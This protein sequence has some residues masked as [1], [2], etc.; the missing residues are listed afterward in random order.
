MLQEVLIGLLQSGAAGALAY[1]LV[2]WL[3]TQWE[4]FANAEPWVRRTTAW[5]LSALLGALPYLAMVAMAYEPAP[6][7]WRGWV[8]R[9]FAVCFVA[10][11]ASQGLHITLRKS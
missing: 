4:W 10:V 11:T 8:E 7:D 5:V 1:P 3:K 9:L 6:Q 2:E